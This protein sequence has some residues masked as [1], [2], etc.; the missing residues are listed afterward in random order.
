MSRYLLI[1]FFISAFSFLVNQKQKMKWSEIRCHYKVHVAVNN[2]TI[3]PE[4][5]NCNSSN[6]Y[7]L[8]K[9]SKSE[10]IQLG[11]IYTYR[12]LVRSCP[13]SP[14]RVE[15]IASSAK[16]SVLLLTHL[17]GIKDR[18]SDEGFIVRKWMTDWRITICNKINFWLKFQ[19]E[20]KYVKLFFS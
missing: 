9:G 2:V 3:F 10:M 11:C 7:E 1:N 18:P 5:K 20:I 12:H 17:E 4:E 8:A 16:M 13:S 19:S 6:W 15:V 14:K